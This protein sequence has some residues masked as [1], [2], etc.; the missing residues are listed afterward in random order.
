M[1]DSAAPYQLGSSVEDRT[2]LLG[3]RGRQLGLLATGLVFA[4]LIVRSSPSGSAF[5]VAAAAVGCASALAFLPIGGRTIEEWAPTVL[6][7]A[8]TRLLRRERWTSQA[9]LLGQ[10]ATGDPEQC[11]PPILDGVRILAARVESDG[12]TA[13]VVHDL[14]LIHI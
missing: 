4:V 1:M 5:L 10:G 13:G 7:W 9:P 6:R 2:V 14:S 8:A 12:R 11:P 3:L